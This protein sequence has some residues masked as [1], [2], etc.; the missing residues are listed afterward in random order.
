MGKKLTRDEFIERSNEIHGYKFD[1]SLVDY[2]NNSTKV[3]IICKEHGVFEQRP[4]DHTKK[5]NDNSKGIGC[6]ECGGV[7]KITLNDF[8]EKSKKLHGNK[9]DYSLVEFDNITSYIK[10][11]CP[12]HGVFE[13]K[14]RNHLKGYGCLKCGGTEKLS[15]EIFIEKSKEIHGDKYDY[16]L[17]QY[18]NINSKVNIICHIHGIFSQ[19]P[20]GHV[21]GKG[22]LM[23]SGKNKLNTEDFIEKS[24]EIH[25]DKYDYSLVVYNNTGEKVKIICPIHGVFEQK[26]NSHIHQKSGCNLCGCE[27][28][29]IKETGNT[30]FFIKKSKI[31][32]GDKYDYSLVDY[33]N[34]LIKVN[35]ICPIHGIFEQ[36]PNEHS[37]KSGCPICRESIGE[38]QIRIILDS[39]NIKYVREKTF[40]EC[41]DIGL[42]RFDFYLP[43]YNM[44]I[45]FDGRQH[46]ETSQLW[47]GEGEL[48]NIQRRDNIKN[49]YCE[50]NNINLIRIKYDE[51]IDLLNLINKLNK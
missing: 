7:K 43:K 31:T 39:N 32:H 5:P 19:T 21:N 27:I 35:I 47:G 41:K 9:Y 14:V 42:L 4:N 26:P 8:I 10:I 2:V 48:K 18:V 3:K 44:C 38:K 16:S 49:N 6:P 51:K 1:Y 28:T 46:F 29:K 45:E 11:I 17:V 20:N 24:K 50:N 37:R 22:C 23:C 15:N 34:S 33:K 30:E 25:G 12:I 40:K 13:Q 36:N